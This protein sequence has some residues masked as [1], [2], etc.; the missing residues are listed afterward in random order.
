MNLDT[1][2]M[3]LPVRRAGDVGGQGGVELK[4]ADIPPHTH[5]LGSGHPCPAPGQA[6]P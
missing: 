2:G 6:L 5:R 1:N 3:L 4:T